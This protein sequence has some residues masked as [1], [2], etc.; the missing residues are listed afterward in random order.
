MVNCN[1]S[2]SHLNVNLNVTNGKGIVANKDVVYPLI[3]DAQHLQ[4]KDSFM[5]RF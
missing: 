1:L 3:P 5:E 4:C 2:V